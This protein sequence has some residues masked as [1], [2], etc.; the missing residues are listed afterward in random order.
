MISSRC[1]TLSEERMRRAARP[2]LFHMSDGRLQFGLGK[3]E[4]KLV[5]KH[6]A[7]PL[8]AVYGTPFYLT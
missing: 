6:I 8:D 2:S 5:R 3:M 4:A 7:K 1:G